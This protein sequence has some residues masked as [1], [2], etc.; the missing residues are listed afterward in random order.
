MQTITLKIED[1][2]MKQFVDMLSAFP[3]NKIEILQDNISIDIAERVKNAEE[4]MANLQQFDNGLDDMKK[5]I[6]AK[7]ANS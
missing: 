3:K 1:S 5:R 6:I 2:H 4:N 7:Y